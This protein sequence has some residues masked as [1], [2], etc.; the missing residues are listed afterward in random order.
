MQN[1]E[2]GNRSY[3]DAVEFMTDKSLKAM[4]KY[5]VGVQSCCS[6][7]DPC[8]QRMPNKQLCKSDK[9]KSFRL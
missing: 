2:S 3:T 7:P 5:G 4:G 9:I 6:G 1:Y 8:D